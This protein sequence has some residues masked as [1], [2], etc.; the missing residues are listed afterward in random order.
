MK[1]LIRRFNLRLLRGMFF[2]FYYTIGF[3]PHALHEPLAYFFAGLG[4]R[5][6]P[7]YRRIV[8][9]NLKIAFG[10]ELSDRDRADLTLRTYRNL[11]MSSMEFVR[12]PRLSKDDI[13]QMVTIEGKE[14]LDRALE[15]GRG[16]LLMSGHFGNWEI[17]A[18]RIVAMGYDLTVVGR[19]QDDSLIND[20]I[21]ELRTR[22]GIRIIPRG[23]PMYQRIMQCLGNNEFVGLVADQNAGDAGI[24]VDL[25]GRLAS[26]FQGPGLFALK[27]D[28]PIIPLFVVRRGYDR[29]HVVVYPPV[30]IEQVGDIKM[31]IY[32]YTQAYIKS[33]EKVVRQHPD[34][35][36]WLHKRWKTRPK[37]ETEREEG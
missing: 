1:K 36:L 22:F 9:D 2:F 12:S 8:S 5:V 34:H 28:C 15:Q 6:S 26:S 20:V 24:F 29:H 11:A 32:Q 4:Y 16:A 3:V 33:I 25:F 13:L 23:V 31:D 30:E 37:W 35:W 17:M 7:K 21:V 27:A 14:H 19:D 10:D 18:M